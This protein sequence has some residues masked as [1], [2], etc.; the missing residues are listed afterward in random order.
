[1]TCGVVFFVSHDNR[2]NYQVS[3]QT[4]KRLKVVGG[5]IFVGC[6]FV[7]FPTWHAANQST[8]NIPHGWHQI[9]STG[10]RMSACVLSARSLQPC[11]TVCFCH[12]MRG[13]RPTRWLG[14]LRPCAQRETPGRISQNNVR[15][16]G[17]Q[18]ENQTIVK[19]TGCCG[20]VIHFQRRQVAV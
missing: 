2:F 7:F 9:R 1:M 19:T 12:Y 10:C 17:G 6:F 3:A 11:S 20:G 18:T 14:S 13:S 8:S 15:G 4:G 5:G 16:Q